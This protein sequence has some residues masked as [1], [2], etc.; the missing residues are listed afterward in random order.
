MFID[1][2]EIS[3]YY[4]PIVGREIYGTK[5]VW[6]TRGSGVVWAE[7]WHDEVLEYFYRSINSIGDML[8]R[9]LPYD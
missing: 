7:S 6:R 1:R 3:F 5:A 4:S 8:R 2:H 9:D